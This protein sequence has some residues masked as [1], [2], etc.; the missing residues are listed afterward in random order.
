MV[1]IDHA[2]LSARD[3]GGQP[4]DYLELHNFLDSTKLHCEDSRH[5]AVLHNTF[6]IGVCE[7]LFGAVITN[8]AGDGIP[9]RELARRH[10]RQDCGRVP[11]L[12]EWLTA[13]TEHKQS[14]FDRPSRSDIV[15]L[16]QNYY[17]GVTND[18]ANN[19]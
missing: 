19:L 10:I 18:R 17:S 4:E 7:Q 1:P 8:S 11:S 5:R 15:W 9:T 16:K 3:F 13:L 14:M 6:G 2:R 12:E